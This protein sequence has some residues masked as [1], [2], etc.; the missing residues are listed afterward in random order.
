MP[1]DVSERAARTGGRRKPRGGADE[2]PDSIA[3]RHPAKDKVKRISVGFAWDLFL[4]AGVTFGVPLFLR[5]LPQWGAAVL[6]LWVVNLVAGRFARETLWLAEVPLFLA[7]FLLQL[8]LG[9]RGNVLTARAYVARG[10]RVEDARSGGVRRV[11]ERWRIG[12]RPAGGR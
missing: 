3:L 1:T 12:E 11:L 7:F 10:W 5:R 9:L 8:W 2:A 4:L 6:G